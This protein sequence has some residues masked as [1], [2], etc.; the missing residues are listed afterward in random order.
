[1]LQCIIT[2]LPDLQLMDCIMLRSLVRHCSPTHHS[3]YSRESQGGTW[4]AAKGPMSC[5]G[6]AHGA[7]GL[8]PLRSWATLHYKIYCY[9]LILIQIP[10][11]VISHHDRGKKPPSNYYR[12]VIYREKQIIILLDRN[13]PR[14]AILDTA[15]ILFITSYYIC[16]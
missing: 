4:H 12:Q 6:M 1:M 11:V 9:F 5:P 7:H 13:Q 8:Q 2:K 10:W 15:G 16:Q 3:G 14:H